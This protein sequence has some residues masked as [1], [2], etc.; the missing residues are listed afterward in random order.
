MCLW[1]LCWAHLPAELWRGV[2]GGHHVLDLWMGSNW[3]WR[4]VWTWNSW[5]LVYYFIHP[6]TATFCTGRNVITSLLAYGWSCSLWH[7]MLEMTWFFQERPV[8]FC[9]QPR[10]RSSPLR[11]ATSQRFTRALSPPGW[12]VQDTW[13]E[14]QTPVRYRWFLSIKHK[15]SLRL[16]SPLQQES[17]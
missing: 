2:W 14:E 9:A 8:W 11:P 4:W 10:C 17:L 7:I 12:S 16:Q 3:G 15:D 5:F 6:A 13:R 1:R